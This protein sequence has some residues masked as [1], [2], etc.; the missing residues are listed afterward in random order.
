[1]T[2]ATPEAT[3]LFTGMR[4]GPKTIKEHTIPR[5]LGGR[6]CSRRVSSTAFN[7]RSSD[8]FDDI[9][10]QP[11]LNA[12]NYLAPLLSA[13]HAPAALQVDL[14]T[15]GKFE[16][17]PGGELGLRSTRIDR[18]DAT[19][20]PT[21]ASA[22]NL[23]SL[24]AFAK[25]AGWPEGKWNQT[26]EIVTKEPVLERRAAVLSPQMEVAAM[27]CILLSFD[28]VLGDDPAR[29]TRSGWLS[30]IRDEIHGIV[31]EGKSADRLVERATWGLQDGANSILQDLRREY[32]SQP[33]TQFEHILVA[34]GDPVTGALDI[35]WSLANTDIWA[36]RLTRFWNGPAFTA[37]AGCGI[38]KSTCRW[39]P[40]VIPS[41]RWQLRSKSDERSAQ[42]DGHDIADRINGIAQRIAARR[43]EFYRTAV[44]LVERKCDDVVRQ[45]IAIL[46]RFP[47][48][49]PKFS[50]NNTTV[51]AGITRRIFR[52]YWGHCQDEEH[53]RTCVDVVR[54]AAERLPMDVRTQ[55]VARDF[56]ECST[57][58]WNEW[59]ECYRSILDQLAPRY[60][61]PGYIQT[62]S[63]PIPSWTTG[64]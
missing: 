58:S 63:F 57:I 49:E 3:C 25:N 38:L 59:L 53:R 52:L 56:P 28:E 17:K 23:H 61:R 33:V 20:A 35:G 1:M 40:V 27:K 15:D 29:F 47:D 37:M 36:F 14:S 19:G 43:H 32:I 51:I 5:C 9:L 55:I 45:G 4:L 62:Q 12:F 24:E 34:S 7:N 6:I 50:T 39:A 30:I 64:D 54:A 2:I 41:V 48:A 42:C 11:Y 10:G 8:G 13:E 60:G 18:K 21:A 22:N 44:D 26:V 16:L 46:A 31:L